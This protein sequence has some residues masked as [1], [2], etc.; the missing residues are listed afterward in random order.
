MTDV[1]NVLRLIRQRAADMRRNSS[2]GDT[3]PELGK[4]AGR[5]LDGIAN[6]IVEAAR[7]RPDPAITT[8][9]RGE[10]VA[11]VF[12]AEQANAMA[13]VVPHPHTFMCVDAPRSAH[14]T[15]LAGCRLFFDGGQ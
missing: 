12:N 11:V 8:D 2:G 5:I 4:F 7:M 13:R 9:S 10:C 6:E 1:D 15:T 14:C 3:D